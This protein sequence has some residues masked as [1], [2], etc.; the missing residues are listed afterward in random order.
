ML[1]GCRADSAA[2]LIGQTRP[3]Q[4]R[5]VA[6]VISSVPVLYAWPAREGN[7]SDVD[8]PRKALRSTMHSN[9][10]EASIAPGEVHVT[11]SGPHTATVSNLWEPSAAFFVYPAAP[12]I[13]GDRFPAIPKDDPS[14]RRILHAL[15]PERLFCGLCKG[16]LVRQHGC[17]GRDKHDRLHRKML[18]Q[19]RDVRNRSTTNIRR[20]VV[21]RLE[22]TASLR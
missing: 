22:L 5:Y 9:Q 11:V 18:N 1:K 7:V 6:S 21:L 10:V 3:E 12:A 8:I 14:S 2:V 13:A 20:V 16:R 19:M 15:K 4:E 17:H